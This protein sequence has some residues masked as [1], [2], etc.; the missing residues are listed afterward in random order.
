MSWCQE[1]PLQTSR[2]FEPGIDH[3]RYPDRDVWV[4]VYGG[5]LARLADRLLVE[6]SGISLDSC[7]PRRCVQGTFKTQKNPLRVGWEL[8]AE[9]HVLAPHPQVRQ[10]EN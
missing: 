1:I 6:G 2:R 10:S 3:S 4:K 9:F 5:F 8:I 7:W